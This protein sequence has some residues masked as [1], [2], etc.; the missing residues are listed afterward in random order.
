MGTKKFWT[1]AKEKFFPGPTDARSIPLNVGLLNE[2]EI[3]FNYAVKD[4]INIPGW[5][6][7][8]LSS[9]SMKS[10]LLKNE[11]QSK[12]IVELET[13]ISAALRDD[14]KKLTLIH[15][16]LSEIVA[17]ATPL[18]IEYTT[19][20]ARFF[21]GEKNTIPMIRNMWIMSMIFLIGFIITYNWSGNS[22]NYMYQSWHL[23][24]SAGLGAYFYSLYTANKYFIDRTFD[25]KYNTFYNNRI[26]I[27]IIAGFILANLID[28]GGIIS[29]TQKEAMTVNDANISFGKT[30]D[31]TSMVTKLSPSIIALLGGYSADAVNKILAR[32]VAMLTTL[33]QGETKDII[34]SKEAEWKSHAELKEVKSKIN[35]AAD[36]MKIIN[37]NKNT[38]DATTLQKLTELME[39]WLK[40][41]PGAQPG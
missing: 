8:D 3:M 10:S 13:E 23:L 14:S 15:A 16:A 1:L 12:E 20:R 19:P 5:V 30:A 27:G 25:P 2:C 24:F 39:N 38:M 26:I 36:L 21:V 31:A 18:T 37:Q 41:G 40:T 33:V 6:G 11:S 35:S 4:G 34:A 17:P 29:G 9:I 32:I 28:V 22:K 7:S